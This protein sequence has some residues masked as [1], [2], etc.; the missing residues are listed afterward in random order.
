MNYE[1]IV[2]CAISVPIIY[3]SRHVVFNIK[4]HGFYRFLGWECIAWLFANDYKYW[5]NNAFSWNQILSWILLIYAS[6]IVIAGVILLKNLGKADQ[7]TR[8]DDSLYSFE[9]TTELVESGLY[10]LI[11][12]PLYGSLIF[13]SWGIYFKNVASLILLLIAILATILFYITAKFDEKECIEYFGERY[14]DYMKR[15]KMFIPFLF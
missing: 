1:I 8:S 15:S 4:S 2:F 6:Y 3:F 7:A 11:R 5:F 9:K 12:H 14:K 10:K 13:L